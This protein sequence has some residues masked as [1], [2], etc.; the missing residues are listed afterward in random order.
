M[1]GPAK[2]SLAGTRASSHPRKKV[3]TEAHRASALSAKAER[4]RVKHVHR[5]NTLMYYALSRNQTNAK[6][7]EVGGTTML[8]PSSALE[9]DGS[10][11]SAPGQMA[12]IFAKP[13]VEAPVGDS[14]AV[15]GSTTSESDT[16]HKGYADCIIISSTSE[17]GGAET[18]NNLQEVNVPDF[19]ED[20]D[21]DIET[22]VPKKKSRKIYDLTQ[23]FQ[24]ECACKLPWAEGILTTMVCCTW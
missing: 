10:N 14:A 24:L 9:Y 13:M 16:H 18:T 4:G 15:A 2:T 8:L 6:P 20:Y 17:D 1:D 5:P 22:L 3:C 12:P 7:L 23:K 11:N 19:D 21:E